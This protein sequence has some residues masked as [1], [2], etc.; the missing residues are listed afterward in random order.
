MALQLPIETARLLVRSFQPEA[1]AE[2]MF[3]VYGDPEV[4]RFIPGGALPD[5]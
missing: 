4:M 3:R 5:E 2:P 1:D